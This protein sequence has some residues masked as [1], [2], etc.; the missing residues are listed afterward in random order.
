MVK[1]LFEV[2][3]LGLSFF[4]LEG[5]FF[6]SWFLLLV[7]FFARRLWPMMLLILVL[8]ALHQLIVV[9]S[10]RFLVLRCFVVLLVFFPLEL[11]ISISE[12][13]H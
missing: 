10:K 12:A 9:S 2:Y 5:H 3:F 6:S 1:R 7:R 4:V 11:I 8:F 13:S